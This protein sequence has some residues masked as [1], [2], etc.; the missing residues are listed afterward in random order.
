[1]KKIFFKRL[2]LVLLILA[3]IDV[4]FI[5]RE[6]HAKDNTDTVHVEIEF[7]GNWI[8]NKYDVD[9]FIDNEQVGTI[10]HGEGYSTTTSLTS[11]KHELIFYKVGNQSVFAKGVFNISSEESTISCTIYAE[12]NSIRIEDFKIRDDA[13]IKVKEAEEKEKQE[14]ISIKNKLC[15]CA[16]DDDKKIKKAIK[17]LGD[18]AISFTGY[19]A[20][21][22]S[23]E[24]KTVIL[25]RA[26]KPNSSNITGADF[27][28]I[29]N[30]ISDIPY[31]TDSKL[32]I[33]KNL[34]LKVDTAIA[35]Y[36]KEANIVS[37][38]PKML[39]SRGSSIKQIEEIDCNDADTV[40][41]VQEA[42]NKAGFDC[43][44]ADGMAGQLTHAAIERYKE[45]HNLGKDDSLDAELID[46][47]R[48]RPK[49][50][51]AIAERAAEEA[52]RAAAEEAEKARV[53]E[54]KAAI[55]TT[56]SEK[57]SNP[58][59]IGN[60]SSHILHY[61]YC[62]SVRDMNEWNKVYF[63]GSRDEVPKIYNSCKR[64]KP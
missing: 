22:S 20:C 61:P 30:D 7:P 60:E 46:Y 12:K 28:I 48:V 52:E 31:T 64:C 17:K 11:G 18:R 41:C 15:K 23:V 58:T 13:A 56:E 47:L 5:N 19:I 4:G 38:N 51:E 43:G 26:G 36:N 6:I 27:Q 57:K 50:E 62:S 2:F 59:Y 21:I 14:L 45:V 25:L 33:E 9:L 63:Y 32:S 34:E 10:P 54:E 37:L 8:F 55:N 35:G 40:K 53:A 3:V 24:E 16:P 1:M 44:P 42:L 29:C 39:T 49:I